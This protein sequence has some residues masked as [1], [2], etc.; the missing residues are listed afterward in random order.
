MAVAFGLAGSL[1]LSAREAP[2]TTPPAD[3]SPKVR[4]DS[5]QLAGVIEE[6]VR[7]FRGVPYAAP[8]VGA[9][10]WK[11]PQPPAAWSGERKAAAAG[12]VCMQQTDKDEVSEDCLTLQVFAPKEA[13]KAPVMVWLHGGA[14]VY[15]AGSKPAYNGA[16]FARDGVVLVSFNYR[17]GP[18][19]FFAHPALT[20]AA[21]PDEPLANYGVMDQI[22]ALQWVHRNIAAFGGDPGN[23][24]IFGESAGGLDVLVLLSAPAAKGLF[25]KAISES[26]GRNWDPLPTLAA[27]ETDGTQLAIHTGLTDA[28]TAEQLR[29][30]SAA[31]LVKSAESDYGPVT[32][33]RLLT[34]SPAQAFA[35][36][37]AFD[38][39][40][41]LG[42]NSYEASLHPAAT[43][44]LSDL[45]ADLK[46]VYAG[47]ATTDPALGIA[48]FNDRYFNAPVR[49]F[50]RHAAAG[51]PAWL[52]HFSYVRPSQR[53]K[54]PGAPHASEIP[55]VFDS[56]DKLSSLSEL[57]PAETRTLTATIHSCWVSFAK[58][59]A[60][61]CQGAPV[62]PAY[63]PDKDELM[64][65]GLTTGVRQ[66]FRQPQ[67]DAQDHVVKFLPAVSP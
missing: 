11:P 24:T 30:L 36:G 15:G 50:A 35:R 33:G 28:A 45:P 40:L 5:G 14:N 64:E 63:S 39:P 47:D 18:L 46:A 17:L 22:A 51:A 21:K 42:S 38:V 52:Y 41:I 56:W 58:K 29:R 55:Y 34:E 13:Q 4:I 27:A 26:P 66:H 12:P 2:A 1:T 62:W 20:R 7:V 57:L 59:G 19:G 54:L 49:W 9:L 65:F 37:H 6:G 23:V 32:D 43:V 16:A 44:K 10:R 3:P 61:S 60:P 48:L 31:M 8:P 67:L 25:N 53:A